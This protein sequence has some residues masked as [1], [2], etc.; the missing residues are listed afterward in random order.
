MKVHEFMHEMQTTSAVLGR[1]SNVSVV[2]EGN[3]AKTDGKTIYLPALPQ[4]VDLTHEQVLAMRGYVD[5]EAGHN[6]H[7]DMPRIM[8]FYDKNNHN[9]RSELSKLHNSLEDV[10]MEQ[11]VLDEYPG[12]W[13]NLRQSHEMMRRREWD[14]LK[15]LDDDV[16]HNALTEDPITAARM[17]INTNKGEDF[18]STHNEL[19]RGKLTDEMDA[20]GKHYAGLARDCQSSEEVIELAKKIYQ[21]SNETPPEEQSPEDFDQKNSEGELSDMEGEESEGEN[22]PGYGKGDGEAEAAARKGEA[23]DQEGEGKGDGSHLIDPSD[24]RSEILNSE[25][26]ID[27]GGGAIGSCMDN[28][29]RGGYKVQTTEYDNYYKRGKKPKKDHSEYVQTVVDDVKHWGEYDSQKLTL[30]SN[31]MVM[32]NKLRR[33]LMARQ[34]RDWDFGRENGRIDSKRLVAASQ[35][36]KAVYKRRT[37]RQDHDTAIT[38]LIDLSG[39]MS[40]RKARVARDCCIALSECFEGTN[41][42]YR[43]SGFSNNGYGYGNEPP[44]GAKY[45]RYER[46]DHCIFKDFDDTLRLTRGSVYLIP[47]A[48]GGNNS[49][50]D[51]VDKELFDLSRR[52][53]ARRVLFVLSDGNV[54]C[55]SDAPT[56]EH[57]RLIK[58]NLALYAAKHNVENLGVGILDS[59]V[60]RIYDNNVVVQN[61]DELSGKVFNKL[62]DLLFRE[63]R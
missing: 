44:R 23:A 52:P 3:E 22:S 27:K 39:S 9:E 45:H 57:Q 31:V 19:V 20:M 59:T 60:K 37:D 1:T 61:V 11:R 49:D 4:Q 5:H 62:T 40:G 6:R 42:S 14:T 26:E 47:E 36:N 8:S 48:I 54:A 53:E 16:V 63:L 56:S 12:A 55:H 51:F 34:Q 2:F 38:V 18:A 28:G 17:G 33:A 13:K 35:G 15:D 25:K 21:Y 58:E 50:Y 29:L 10:Y 30:R 46:L 32:K 41:M 24:D 43:I 7:S